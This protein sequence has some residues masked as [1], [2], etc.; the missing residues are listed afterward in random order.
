MARLGLLLIGIVG[1]A[2]R[3]L[4]RTHAAPTDRV[5]IAAGRLALAVVAAIGVLFDAL[6]PAR[7]AARVLTGDVGK[8][9]RSSVRLA[10][11]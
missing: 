4:S 3:Q 6:P 8:P 11:T 2:T 7:G 9:A 10:R 5:R 1:W